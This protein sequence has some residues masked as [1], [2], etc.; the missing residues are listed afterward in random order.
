MTS[1]Y[2]KYKLLE[3]DNTFIVFDKNIHRMEL[4]AVSIPQREDY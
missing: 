3:I 4:I 2:E 1:R